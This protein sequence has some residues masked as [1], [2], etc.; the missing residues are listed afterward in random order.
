M[1]NPA[2][3]PR[4]YSHQWQCDTLWNRDVEENLVLPLKKKN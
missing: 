1:C 3:K 2:H 4:K